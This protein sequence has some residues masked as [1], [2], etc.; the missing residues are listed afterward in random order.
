MA[1]QF[2]KSKIDFDVYERADP[3]SQIDWGKEAK[4]I[5]DAF[6]NIAKDRTERKA[7]VEKSFADQQAKL[8]ELGEYDNPTA[9]QVMMNAGQDG[10]NKLLD[11]KNLVKRGLMKP[12]DAT[13]FQQNQLNGFNLLK[14]NMGAFDKTFQEYT[15][16]MQDGESA[17]AEQYFATLTEGFANL[18]NISVQTDPETGNVS[19]LR[20]DENGDPVEGGDSMTV[21]R[22]TLLMKQKVNNFDVGGEVQKI[23][24]EIGITTTSIAK[25]KY[26]P[27][28]VITKEMMSK[29]EDEYLESEKGKGFLMNKVKQITA[30]PMNVNTMIINAGMQTDN[31]EDYQCGS[32]EDYDNWMAEND[33]DEAN[34]PFLVLEFGKD[35]QYHANFNETQMTKAEEYVKNQIRGAVDVS[36]EEDVKQLNEKDQPRAKSAAE[37]SIDKDDKEKSSRLGDYEIALND[38]DPKKRKDMTD[39]LFKKRNDQI[40]ESNKGKSDEEKTVLIDDIRMVQKEV[41][42]GQGGTKTVDVRVVFMENGDEIPLEG[43]TGD[44]MNTLDLLLNPD[45]NLTS[46]D[47]AR[48]AKDRELDLEREVQSKSDKTRTQKGKSTAINFDNPTMV[49]GEEYATSDAYLKD[50]FGDAFNADKY[51]ATAD[52]DA[53]VAKNWAA[54]VQAYFPAELI[55]QFQEANQPLT[56]NYVDKGDKLPDGSDADVDKLVMTLGGKELIIDITKPTTNQKEIEKW[57]L[58]IQAEEDKRRTTTGGSGG[59]SSR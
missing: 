25:Q 17:P 18:N 28:V 27:N 47:I 22:L 52:T 35:N 53:G 40:R 44:Q 56:S 2:S 14:Q 26:G 1:N 13:M 48:L 3:E 39:K 15:K 29:V 49:G 30:N 45:N 24:G 54:Y 51:S 46:D 4:V 43:N 19:L 23:K 20:L 8:N 55:T 7:A 59:G 16:R 36:Y 12:S 38:P 11:V 10:A 32:Q 9:Q 34:N 58:E 33:N 21:N 42:D 41:D 57:M 37:L 31:G 5:S 50:V 6:G